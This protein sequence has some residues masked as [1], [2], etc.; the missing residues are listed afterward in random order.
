[1]NPSKRLTLLI[2]RS[3]LICALGFG[4]K[5]LRAEPRSTD[6]DPNHCPSWTECGFGFCSPDTDSCILCNFNNPCYCPNEGCN[7]DLGGDC[8]P[9]N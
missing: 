1:M 4:A 3:V 6:C 2:V 9:I 5:T 7:D 8:V